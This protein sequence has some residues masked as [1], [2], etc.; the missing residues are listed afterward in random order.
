MKLRELLSIGDLKKGKILT[1]EIGLDNEVDSA[2]VLEAIDIENWSRKNQLILTSC[3]I[4]Q[5]KSWKI[6]S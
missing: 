3:M 1:K 2:M 6:F 5:K 4:Y